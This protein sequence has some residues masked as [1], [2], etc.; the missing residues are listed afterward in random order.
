MKPRVGL[1]AFNDGERLIGS[2]ERMEL[3]RAGFERAVNVI[4]GKESPSLRER[5]DT[6]ID[7]VDTVLEQEMES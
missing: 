6:V 1:A 2:Q 5:F 3:H 7:T 4:E